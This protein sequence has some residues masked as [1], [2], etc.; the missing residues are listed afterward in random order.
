MA[1]TRPQ[2]ATDLTPE[3]LAASPV[4]CPGSKLRW[5]TANVDEGLPGTVTPLTWSMYFPPTES[6][7]RGCWVDLGVLPNSQRPIPD[8]VDARFLSVAYGRAIANLDQMGRMA[9]RVPGGS[10]AL[11]EAQLFGSVQG[12]GD[13]EP[14]GLRK[15]RRY[16]FVAAKFPRALRNA[17]RSLEPCAAETTRWWRATVFESDRPAGD[18]AVATLVEA[19]RRFEA[20]LEIH[21]VLSMACQGV[22]GRVETMATNAGIEGLQHELIRS[23]EGTAEFELVRDLWRLSADSITVEDF[24]HRHGY[25]GPREGL[26]ESTVWREDS[27]P[28]VELAATYRSRRDAEDVDQLVLRR[29]REHAAAVRRLEQALGAFRS[30]PARALVRFA[31][32]AP[33]WRETGRASI[34]R[35]VDVARAASR[36]IGRD[37]SDAGVLG[38]PTDIWFLTIDEIARGDRDRWA[39]LVGQRQAHH[40]MFDRISL[41]HVFRGEPDVEITTT[42]ADIVAAECR[43]DVVEGLGV[44]AGTAEGIVRVVRDLDDADIDEGSVLVCRATDPSWASLFPLAE[45]VVTDVGSAMSHAAIV[46]RELGLPCVAGTRN[47]TTVLRDGMRVRVDGTSGRVEIL[48]DAPA[49]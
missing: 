35:A 6:T 10:A 2:P 19:R 26:V 34:L 13:P 47:G 37:L 22:M 24:L 46:C 43:P 45:A 11:M 32:H 48:K 25:H 15:M 44:S 3:D 29:R 41:P 4:H 9:A 23:D 12:G 14:T 16:P 1:S 42:A 49:P 18:L 31:A 21:M 33:T 39:E 28:I 7:M 5:T 27:R 20:I 8:D 40:A 36:I 17:M 38:D 30:I